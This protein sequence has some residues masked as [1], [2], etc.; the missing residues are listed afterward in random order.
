MNQP[1]TSKTET[2]NQIIDDISEMDGKYLTFWTDKQLFGIPIRDV[3][4]IVGMQEIAAIPEFPAYAKG[5]INLRGS[6]IPLIDVRLRFGK[7]E[8][9]YNERTCI[10]VTS[11]CE[12]E[13]GFIVDAVNEVADIEEQ[14]ISDP[15]ALSE[16]YANVYLTG[17]AN[18]EGRI[19]LL[20]DATKMLA[21]DIAK[22]LM[23]AGG[24]NN[25]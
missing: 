13:I 23:N 4:Q 15:P 3:V 25:V 10:I 2:M 14:D 7:P 22:K 8:T 5:I 12:K 21:D 11:I 18:Q 1:E 6:I 24:T 19:V 17:I 16:D 9:E 20:V